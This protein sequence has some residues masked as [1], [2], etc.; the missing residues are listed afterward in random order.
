MRLLYVVPPALNYVAVKH[1]SR[2]LNARKFHHAR[3]AKMIRR[4]KGRRNQIFQS[5]VH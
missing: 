2:S 4:E 3:P 1:F 5:Y